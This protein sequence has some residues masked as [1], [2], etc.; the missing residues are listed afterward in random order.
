[1][2]LRNN[3]NDLL[4]E[5]NA[6]LLW[7]RGFNN[8]FQAKHLF[9]YK[10]NCVLLTVLL[11]SHSYIYL[12]ASYIKIY[13]KKKQWGSPFAAPMF[14]SGSWVIMRVNRQRK[15]SM[16]HEGKPR[17]EL[18]LILRHCA[19]GKHFKHSPI[20][21]L[22]TNKWRFNRQRLCLSLLAWNVTWKSS[23]E[24]YQLSQKSS[25]HQRKNWRQ[26]GDYITRNSS[27]GEQ[28]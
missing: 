21:K 16:D 25:D 22:N 13:T 9:K 24:C 2:C 14:Y 23:Y 27:Q 20:Y 1:M 18:C 4:V 3:S 6:F 12:T 17:N 26:P 19:T 11:Q 10:N 28:P 15:K 5:G 8:H 7:C